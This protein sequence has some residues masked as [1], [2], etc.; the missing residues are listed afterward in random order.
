M[1][2]DSRTVSRLLAVVSLIVALMLTF[3]LKPSGT[4]TEDWD[5]DITVGWLN[6]ALFIL[7]LLLFI[8]S[9][10]PGKTAR[11]TKGFE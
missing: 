8:V 5:L 10:R 9:S 6:T 3:D 7:S 4:M 2:K 1:K 11:E